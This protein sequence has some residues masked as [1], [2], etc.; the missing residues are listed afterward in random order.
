MD[1]APS[2]S[3][4]P[5]VSTTGLVRNSTK[6]PR[7]GRHRWSSPSRVS[8]SSRESSASGSAVAAVLASLHAGRLQG[9]VKC[10]ATLDERR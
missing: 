10:A 8:A 1:T 5:G 3:V 9:H 2:I 7:R 4:M 6:L